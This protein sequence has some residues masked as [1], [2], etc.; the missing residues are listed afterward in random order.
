MND[1][2]PED[3]RRIG[4]AADQFE[5]AWRRGERPRV[6]DYLGG[7]AD[8]V[9]GQIVRHLVEIEL[10]LRRGRGERPAPEEYEELLPGW[11]DCIR[12]AFAPEIGRGEPMPTSPFLSTSAPG[13]ESGTEPVP[14]ELRSYTVLEVLGRGAM[15]VVYKGWQVPLDRFVAIKVIVPGGSSDR[16]RREA[17]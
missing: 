3:L 16:F 7:H 17:R 15:G 1:L 8:V 10:E 14:P 5:S 13:Q 11:A 4:E 6:A 12:E 2:G 9:R